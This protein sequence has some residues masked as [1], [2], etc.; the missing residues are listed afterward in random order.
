MNLT[1]SFLNSIVSFSEQAISSEVLHQVKRCLL[2]YVGVVYAGRKAVSD[3][4]NEI[5]N[6]GSAGS[7]TI[8]GTGLKKD[9]YTASFANGFSAHILELDDGHR[10]G[11]PHL[12]APII[13]AMLATAE[14]E[15]LSFEAFIRGILVGYETTIRLSTAIQPSHKLKGFHSTGTCGTVGVACAVGTA[16]GLSSNQLKGSLSAATSSAAGLLQ[17]LDDSSQLKPYNIANAVVSGITAGY[18]GRCGFSGPDDAIGG[19]R[20]F[21]RTFSDNWKEDQLLQK[22]DVPSILQI[23]VKPYAA[24]RHAH[25]AIDAALNIIRD[26]AIDIALISDVE[27]QTYKLAID[28]HNQVLFD[29][30]SAAKMSIPYSVA[31]AIATGNCGIEAFEETSRKRLDIQHL[32]GMIRIVENARLSKEYPSKRGAIVRITMIGGNVFENEVEYPLGEPENSISD[33]ELESKFF[34]LMKYA[35]MTKESSERVRDYVWNLEKS[36]NVFLGFLEK[37]KTL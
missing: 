1:D 6:I 31:A 20:G 17:V 24:C 32:A 25:A 30:E 3:R 34:S 7:C 2:D 36:Y 4:L 35:G 22:S 11:A 18:M 28:G 33:D 29:T 16:L 19:K 9:I 14:Q 10:V 15:N 12:E 13:T 21:L 5:I 23:Y 8:V 27:I 26:N 37:E